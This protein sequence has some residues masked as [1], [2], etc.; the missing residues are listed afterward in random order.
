MTVHHYVSN[1]SPTYL[2]EGL[3]PGWGFLVN[4]LIHKPVLCC[5]RNLGTH[6]LSGTT[7]KLYLRAPLTEPFFSFQSLTESLYGA[8]VNVILLF[9]NA[10]AVAT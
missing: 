10:A 7:V 5:S 8:F 9:Q 4:V 1:I 6:Q 3:F 2:D